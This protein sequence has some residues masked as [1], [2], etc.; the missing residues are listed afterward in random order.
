MDPTLRR[1]KELATPF[2]H[3]LDEKITM[4]H[5]AESYPYVG[6]VPTNTRL[7][8]RRSFYRTDR[9]AWRVADQGHRLPAPL[10]VAPVETQISCTV[11]RGD[12]DEEISKGANVQLAPCE[13]DS[14]PQAGRTGKAIVKTPTWSAQWR[15]QRSRHPEQGV[16]A[17]AKH[18]IDNDQEF[19]RGGSA[20]H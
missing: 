20:Q 12:G 4:V 8:F 2:C 13:Y 18:Y 15:C 9:P 3:D 16:I 17:T 6:R 1:A 14:R 10:T 5:G 11:W 19:E 7:A